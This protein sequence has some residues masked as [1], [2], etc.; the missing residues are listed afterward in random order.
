MDQYLKHALIWFAVALMLFGCAPTT[1]QLFNEYQ[2]AYVYETN[3]TDK[4]IDVLVTVRIRGFGN[5]EEKR[6]AWCKAW[7][8]YCR[9]GLPGAGMSVSSKIPEI[10]VDLREDQNGLVINN[11]ILGH[12]MR[13]TLKLHDERMNDPDR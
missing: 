4:S 1:K 7:P 3:P 5:Q 2:A 6:E 8:V 9:P 11:V 13:H 12:E 10:W